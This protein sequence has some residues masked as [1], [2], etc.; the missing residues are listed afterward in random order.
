MLETRATNHQGDDVSIE[1]EFKKIQEE[2]LSK[3]PVIIRNL[4][5]PNEVDEIRNICI[6]R[7]TNE[8]KNLPEINNSTPNYHTIYQNNEASKV[9]KIIHAFTFFYW[10]KDSD[11]IAPYFKRMFKLRNKLSGLPENYALENIEDGYV[12]IPVVQHYPRGGGYMQEHID[13]DIKQKV[14]INVVLGKHGTDF[15]SGGL[16]YRNE[17]NKKM[18]VDA[19]LNPGDA[20]VFFP[21]ISHGID[22]IDPEIKIDWEKNDGRWMCFSTLIKLSSMKR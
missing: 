16:F 6:K 1:L 4:L 11:H 18:Y 14:V 15:K 8:P 20:F 5:T 17:N 2:I 7:A 3:K 22:P 21:K 19:C 13:P 12:S 10:N 9:K